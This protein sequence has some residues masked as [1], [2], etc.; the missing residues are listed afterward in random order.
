WRWERAPLFWYS[1]CWD[2]K[3]IASGKTAKRSLAINGTET[4]NEAILGED[5][6]D[7]PEDND[8]LPELF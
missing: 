6:D 1:S 8:D 3:V 7:F 2:L 5:S 4:E